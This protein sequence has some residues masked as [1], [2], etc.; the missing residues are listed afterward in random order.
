MY[1]ILSFFIG[2]CLFAMQ[3]APKYDGQ[4]AHGRRDRGSGIQF[5]IE[6]DTGYYGG[7]GIPLPKNLP[8]MG[9]L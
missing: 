4:E 8:S 1:F 9:I 2:S 5:S 3:P 7:G 6:F